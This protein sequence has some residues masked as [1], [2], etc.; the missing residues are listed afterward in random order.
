MLEVFPHVW[1][2]DTRKACQIC[3]H[4]EVAAT[5]NQAVL[6]GIAADITR[7]VLLLDGPGEASKAVRPSPSGGN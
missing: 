5:L 3:I 1:H 6:D 7:P 4:A 2:S